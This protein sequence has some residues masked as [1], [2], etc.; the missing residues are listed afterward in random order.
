[1]VTRERGRGRTGVAV[2]SQ[3]KKRPM[4]PVCDVHRELESLDARIAAKRAE[5]EARGALRHCGAV[6]QEEKASAVKSTL[7]GE[8]D[9]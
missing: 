5:F 8:A 6:F 9:T 7:Q 4:K 2:I 3:E 1:M